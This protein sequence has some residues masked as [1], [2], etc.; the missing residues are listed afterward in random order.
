[1]S[2]DV[3]QAEMWERQGRAVK[4]SE[5]SQP[6][7]E[8]RKRGAK[9]E[10]VDSRAAEEEAEVCKPARHPQASLQILHSHTTLQVLNQSAEALAEG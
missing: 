5:L 8:V 10:P 9:D 6:A 1:M 4:D 3:A 2:W 7:K